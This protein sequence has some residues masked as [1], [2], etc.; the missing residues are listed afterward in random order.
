MNNQVRQFVQTE[1][2]LTEGFQHLVGFCAFLAGD[3]GVREVREDL[4][5]AARLQIS[6]VPFFIFD[7]RIALAGA[8][9]PE[10]FV[11]ALQA[12]AQGTPDPAIG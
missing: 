10:V 5:E 8:Q 6:G 1:G 9:P 12:A 3:A 11:Q 7:G 4:S 2:A